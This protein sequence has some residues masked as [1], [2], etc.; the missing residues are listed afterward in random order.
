ME[1][2]E[3]KERRESSKGTRGREQTL[4][5]K[6]ARFTIYTPPERV[7]PPREEP[8]SIGE[9]RLERGKNNWLEKSEA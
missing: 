3:E 8:S 1:E 7:H 4:R 5:A 2:K 6:M 9:E